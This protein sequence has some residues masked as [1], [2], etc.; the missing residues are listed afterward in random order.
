MKITGQGPVAWN[1]V[2]EA[3]QQAAGVKGKDK[4]AQASPAPAGAGEDAIQFSSDSRFIR[5]LKTHLA[6]GDDIR[7]ARVE[8]IRARLAAGSYNVP[9]E[10]VAAAILKEMGR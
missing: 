5:E 2:R 1:R 9:A 7:S 4:P 8:A 6:G 3:Y 10:D